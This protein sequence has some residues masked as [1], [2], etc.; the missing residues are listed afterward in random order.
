MYLTIRRIWIWKNNGKEVCVQK[1]LGFLNSSCN[2]L[3]LN[4]QT[5]PERLHFNH[6]LLG[7]F[8]FHCHGGQKQNYRNC[9]TV[10]ILQTGAYLRR[11]STP[12]THLQY[13]QF[14]II[15]Y[16]CL[17]TVKR[18]SNGQKTTR[19]NFTGKAQPVLLW[20]RSANHHKEFKFPK[21]SF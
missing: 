12:S 16:A 9:I 18:S 13:G 2:R 8:K 14:R 1:W 17:W 6:I 3:L 20:G 21:T 5:Q 11:Q 7:W 19:T 4:P 10:H 15:N